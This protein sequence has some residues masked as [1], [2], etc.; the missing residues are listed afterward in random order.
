MLFLGKLNF[1]IFIVFIIALVYTKFA[2]GNINYADIRYDDQ[3]FGIEP[4]HARTTRQMLEMFDSWAVY[5]PS[6]TL[7]QAVEHILQYGA[8]LRLQILDSFGS[9]VYDHYD[10]Y[11]IGQTEALYRVYQETL[12]RKYNIFDIVPSILARPDTRPTQICRHINKNVHTC[13]KESSL[14]C[15]TIQKH[16]YS[17]PHVT[18]TPVVNITRQIY[19]TSH[20]K[21]YFPQR[22]SLPAVLTHLKSG[23]LRLTVGLLS[24]LLH[25]VQ[26]DSFDDEVRTAERNV[27]IKLMSQTK[28]HEI[29]I[30]RHSLQR[31][32]TVSELLKAIFDRHKTMYDGETNKDFAVLSQHVVREVEAISRNIELLG[33]VYENGTIHLDYLMNLVLP[34]DLVDADV[35]EAR[36]YLLEKIVDYDIVNRYLKVE[37]YL[38]SGPDQLLMEILGQIRDI[39]FAVD[40][41]SALHVH[42]RFWHQSHMINNLNELLELFDAY[43]NLRNVPKFS[44]LVTLIDETRNS[45]W[46]S[47]NVTVEILCNNPRA[48]LR[49]GLEIVAQCALVNAAT[50]SN[51]QKIFR[52]LSKD[53]SI[54]ADNCDAPKDDFDKSFGQPTESIES[55]KESTEVVA[56]KKFVTTESS[57]GDTTTDEPVTPATTSAAKISAVLHRRVVPPKTTTEAPTTTEEL[58]ELVRNRKTTT[59]SSMPK[60]KETVKLEP[61]GRPSTEDTHERE[62][63]VTM[64][65]E[66]VSRSQGSTT[67][68]TDTTARIGRDFAVTVK[69]TAMEDMGREMTIAEKSIPTEKPTTI[70][71]TGRKFTPTEEP[72]TTEDANKK[73]KTTQEATT[74]AEV[75][76][77][78]TTTGKPTTTEKIRELKES[79]ESTTVEQM[80]DSKT[81]A[82]PVTMEEIRREFTTTRKPTTIEEIRELATTVSPKTIKIMREFVPSEKPGSMERIKKELTT[83]EETTTIAQTKLATDD[84][85]QGDQCVS[86]A[87]KE[88]FDTLSGGTS[89]TRPTSSSMSQIKSM[90]TR[91]LDL[92]TTVA[93]PT[94]SEHRTTSTTMTESPNRRSEERK[95]HE[96]TSPEDCSGESGCPSNACSGP[97]CESTSESDCAVEGNCPE[98]LIE[99]CDDPTNCSSDSN[100]AA[101]DPHNG[102]A[103]ENCSEATPTQDLLNCSGIDCAKIIHEDTEESDDCDGYDCPDDSNSNESECNGAECTSR[104]ELDPPTTT[105]KD[106]LLLKTPASVVRCDNKDPHHQRKLQRLQKIRVINARQATAPPPTTRPSIFDDDGSDELVYSGTR[107]RLAS[108]ETSLE[109]TEPTAVVKKTHLKS[110]QQSLPPWLRS[111][112]NQQGFLNR[113]QYPPWYP[114]HLQSFSP[115][116]I[117]EDNVSQ[118]DTMSHTVNE[119]RNAFGPGMKPKNN[120]NVDANTKVYLMN[121]VTDQRH[122]PSH[123]AH[124]TVQSRRQRIQETTVGQRVY[125]PSEEFAGISRRRMENSL[126][127]RPVLYQSKSDASQIE[128][129]RKNRSIIGT[130]KRESRRYRTL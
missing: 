101:E 83:T 75:G 99:T 5:R 36:D 31:T 119:D 30:D 126:R 87:S 78:F 44:D 102:C 28:H 42:A 10:D 25:N 15:M 70:G 113:Q 7:Q 32:H 79:A 46:D 53:G 121:H 4:E 123:P 93:I 71:D 92:Q 62:I 19:K 128:V 49:L 108:S 112:R 9:L 27:M 103:D 41:A 1:N 122:S 117:G 88:G 116:R 100:K 34:P 94:T 125:T 43:E 91:Q 66:F 3:P 51:I 35:I 63:T 37:K 12:E 98:R 56:R 6:Y 86:D 111:R 89:N 104:E 82:E 80:R 40:L 67:Q 90:M 61:T 18:S 127:A 33:S 13:L 59:E 84:D 114:D 24:G 107:K 16:D 65:E 55:E 23:S 38:Q 110:L 2:T 85:C 115:N 50:Q 106:K 129:T 96:T 48:C 39:N 77:E 81:S 60:S 8:L 72:K 57:S 45:L 68:G 54:Y 64:G 69:S 20:L 22:F 130:P 58:F 52:Y 14:V 105:S 109:L 74:I 118:R 95:V 26:Y 97:D 21:E 11:S 124:D 73:F 17:H 120:T 76:R 47:K 29:P